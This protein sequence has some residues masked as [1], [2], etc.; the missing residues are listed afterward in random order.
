MALAQEHA[1]VPLRDTV[2]LESLTPLAAFHTLGKGDGCFLLES[3]TGTDKWARYSFVGL[4]PAL[5]L[6][7]TADHVE[8]I[9]EEGTH[10]EYCEEPWRIL[11]EE[12]DRWRAPMGQEERFWG[13]AVGYAS[14]EVVK[15][16]EPTV[17]ISQAPKGD[18]AHDFAF[19]FGGPVLIFDNLQ[20]TIS[21]VVPSR[22][23]AHASAA[24]AYRVAAQRLAHIR[25]Q[26]LHI[27]PLPP[28]PWPMAADPSPQILAEAQSTFDREGFCK[29]VRTAQERIRAGD[30][31][32]VVLS[33]KMR[34][35]SQGLNLL[36]AYRLM[37]A[38]N[39]S[40]Y[41]YFLRFREVT[42]AGASPETLVRLDRGVA[43]VRPI[44]GTR[45]RGHTEEEDRQAAHE[46]LEDPKELAEHVMLVDL[47]RNDLGRVG[48]P[49]SIQLTERLVIERYSHVMHIVSNVRARLAPDASALDLLRATFPAGTLSGAPKVRAMQIIGELEPEPRGVYGGAVGYVG[50]DGN[51]DMAI[52]IRTLVQRDDHVEIQAGA[53]VVEQSDPE[54]EWQETLNKARAALLALH[55]ARS[56]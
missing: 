52:A 16:F 54:T 53:G 19:A 33:Q 24:E 14:F 46:L 6:R 9:D 7:A 50:F 21:I 25:Q 15:H 27:E 56:L 22:I 41:M 10:G 17:A 1:V 43:E 44:A 35:P 20:H 31:F 13:G 47:G 38:I 51:M 32:Q 11:Q 2:L 45:P 23:A 28:I 8:R 39:P 3:V 29:A 36:T 42:I 30:I 12:L 34:V 40:P 4:Q 55:H 5:I 48:Q 18:D 37:R 26:L 49:G